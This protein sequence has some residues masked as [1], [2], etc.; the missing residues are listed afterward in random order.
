M[1]PGPTVSRFGMRFGR[2]EAS[3]S[4]KRGLQNSPW[5]SGTDGLWRKS[6]QRG[7]WA[8]AVSQLYARAERSTMGGI[9]WGESDERITTIG[10]DA[11][12][13]SHRNSTNCSA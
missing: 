6:V 2:P 1:E 12:S 3:R 4:L 10:G 5:A 13:D 8:A 9:C 11:K 7:S